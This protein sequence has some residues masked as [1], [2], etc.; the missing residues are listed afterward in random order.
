MPKLY[1]WLCLNI[2]NIPEMY[3]WYTWDIPWIY[4][5]Y[6]LDIHEIYQGYTWD[7]QGVPKKRGISECYHVCFIA[8]S[9]WSLEYS[10]FIHLKI[11]THVL[12]ARTN[13]FLRD[14]RELRNI[15]RICVFIT[16]NYTVVNRC[17][18]L[19]T[20]HILI[21][22]WHFLQFITFSINHITS[23]YIFMD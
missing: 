5:T 13:P 18:K 19:T 12:V 21:E 1:L 9:I 10:F 4:L 7:I 17:V 20:M 23:F 14:I 22:C 6:T 16:F 3:I 15:H 8:H 2:Q 11:E